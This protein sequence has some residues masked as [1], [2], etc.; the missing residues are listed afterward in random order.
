MAVALR[1]SSEVSNT[2]QPFAATGAV[3]LTLGATAQ[4]GDLLVCAFGYGA[5]RSVTSVQDN[6][7]NNFTQ[8][9]GV[10]NGSAFVRAEIYYLYLAAT[11]T[12]VTVTLS[13]AAAGG[14]VA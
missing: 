10:F 5:N 6:N 2:S 9:V 13:S 1:A 11:A 3:T 4:A 14:S 8:L 7:A 12:S